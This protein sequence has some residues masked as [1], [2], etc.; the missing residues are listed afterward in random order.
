MT[1]MWTS[2]SKSYA[3][4][5][6]DFIEAVHLIHRGSGIESPYKWY[7]TN[8]GVDNLIRKIFNNFT[9]SLN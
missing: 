9:S 6:G 7:R 3:T 1:H 4:G 8:E 5:G 2:G